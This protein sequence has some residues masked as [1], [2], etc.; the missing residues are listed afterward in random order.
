M[1]YEEVICCTIINSQLAQQ[2]GP[3]YKKNK[4]KHINIENKNKKCKIFVYQYFHFTINVPI[5]I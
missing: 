1:K 3:S 2:Q 5:L 4:I